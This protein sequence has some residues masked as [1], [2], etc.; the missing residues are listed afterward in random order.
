MKN[1]HVINK[2]PA[3]VALTSH[4][5]QAVPGVDF[6][7]LPDV[8]LASEDGEQAGVW[9]VELNKYKVEHHTKVGKAGTWALEENGKV[10]FSNYGD[11]G[12]MFHAL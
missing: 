3:G 7:D 9:V 5:R 10:V 4:L 2:Q 12:Y 1:K 6:M 8:V 11:N